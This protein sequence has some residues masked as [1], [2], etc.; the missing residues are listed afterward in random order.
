MLKQSLIYVILT[1]FV[2]IFS[3]Y[4]HLL[5]TY[6]DQLYIYAEQHVAP[7]FNHNHTGS[8]FSKMIALIV[9]PVV[10]AAIPALIY[11]A[12]KGKDMPYFLTLTWCLWLVV[13]LSHFLIR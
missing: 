4:F 3:A 13:V 5:V 6:I 2:V 8:I 12:I 1:I 10:L 7:L 11:R 9:I